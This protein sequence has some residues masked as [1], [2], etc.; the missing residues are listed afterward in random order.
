MHAHNDGKIILKSIMNH[1]TYFCCRDKFWILK[2]E[3]CWRPVSVMPSVSMI[4]NEFT[5]NI[6]DAKTRF[7]NEIWKKMKKRTL[8]IFM[9]FQQFRMLTI[10]KYTN[11]AKIWK[12]LEEANERISIFFLFFFIDSIQSFKGSN[13][14]L[15]LF[16]RWTRYTTECWTNFCPA[17]KNTHSTIK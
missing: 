3:Q 8:D 9:V 1:F 16:S 12:I 17:Q 4:F 7:S 11:M 10:I 14:F 15:F 2:Y 5:D 6:L 13:L